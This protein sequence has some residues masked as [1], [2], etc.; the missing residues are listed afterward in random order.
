M[1]PEAVELYNK[2]PGKMEK[3]MGFMAQL[4]EFTSEHSE[5]G[6]HL[7]KSEVLALKGFSREIVDSANQLHCTVDFLIRTSSR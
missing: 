5:M 6:A 4:N 7:S 1:S 2:V 3:L